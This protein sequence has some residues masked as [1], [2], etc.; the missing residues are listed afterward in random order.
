MKTEEGVA[1]EK[2][3][4]L[5]QEKNMLFFETSAKTAD[6]VNESFMNL[7]SKIVQDLE[8]TQGKKKET[9]NNNLELG[10]RGAQ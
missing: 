8:K 1:T 3:K 7:T 5:A 4:E 2:A 9:P 10:S 6:H